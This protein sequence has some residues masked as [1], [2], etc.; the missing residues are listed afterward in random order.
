MFRIV[1]TSSGDIDFVRTFVILVRQGSATRVAKGAIRAGVRSV[2][3]RLSLIPC[4]LRQL[5]RDPRHRLCA[6]RASAIRAMAIR[7]IQGRTARPEAHL[8]A[9]TTAGDGWLFH[10]RDQAQPRIAPKPRPSAAALGWASSTLAPLPRLHL[11]Q[12][13]RRFSS[14]FRP[15][16]DHG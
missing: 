12:S 2:A 1:Q 13:V 7:L 10:L 14:V 15:P 9:I 8:A 6:G 5:H 16:R 3:F 11:K 4:K